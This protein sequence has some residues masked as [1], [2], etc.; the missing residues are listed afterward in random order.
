MLVSLSELKVDPG[1]YVE[2]A[3]K[4]TVYITKDG[5]KV[6]KITSAKTD[7]VTAAKELFG[8]LPPDT[9]LEQLRL[10]RLHD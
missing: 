10:E 2:L 9:T 3:D 4:E 7:S 1:K 5:E 8:I 6:A